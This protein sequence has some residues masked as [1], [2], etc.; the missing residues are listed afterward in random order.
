ML[1]A[2]PPKKNRGKSALCLQICA[3][4]APFAKVFV[5]HGTPGTVEYECIDH[6]KLDKMPEPAFWKEEATRAKGK[7][8]CVIVDDYS[9]DVDKTEKK[10]IEILL[11]TCASLLGILVLVTAHAHTNIAPKWR[12]GKQGPRRRREQPRRHGSAVP[13]ARRADGQ[14]RRTLPADDVPCERRAQRGCQQ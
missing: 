12:L 5:L 9:T 14:Q 2:P 1:T 10:N 3:R 11:R 13:H 8:L 6:V 4:S 7:P